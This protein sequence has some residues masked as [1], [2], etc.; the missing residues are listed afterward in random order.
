MT[1]IYVSL[2]Y[3]LNDIIRYIYCCPSEIITTVLQFFC[4]GTVYLSVL[5]SQNCQLFPIQMGN[6][7]LW[8]YWF[9]I[10]SIYDGFYEFSNI[11]VSNLL[12]WD[13]NTSITID[14]LFTSV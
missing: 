10:F 13:T 5:G 4:K 9:V 2:N 11:P 7:S 3:K 12:I 6:I 8:I 1:C 14:D